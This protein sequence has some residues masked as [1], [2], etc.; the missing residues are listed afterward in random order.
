MSK[1]RK[2]LTKA[3]RIL[4]KARKEPS[5]TTQDPRQISFLDHFISKAFA[6]LDRAIEE[7]LRKAE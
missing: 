5:P 6:A 3:E 1:K 7:T 4:E 2:R